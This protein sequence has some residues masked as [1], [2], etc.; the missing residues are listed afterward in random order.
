MAAQ[1]AQE[2]TLLQLAWSLASTGDSCEA[3]AEVAHRLASAYAKRRE[4]VETESWAR[5]AIE[6]EQQCHR[7]ALLANHLMFLA[8]VLER[9]GKIPEAAAF[10]ER[11][12]QLYRQ[13]YGP[14][15]REVAY[16]LSVA[17][18]LCRRCGRQPE[19]DAYSLEAQSI[20]RE[21]QRG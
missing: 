3:R 4:P 17:A 6:E 14:A 18:N 9:A 12:V 11:G 13:T 15:H 8:Q 7:P 1:P 19:A 21:S 20:L 2:A 10:A 5:R 16:V